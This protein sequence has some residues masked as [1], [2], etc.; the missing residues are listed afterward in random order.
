LAPEDY[1]TPEDYHSYMD[2]TYGGRI[3]EAN[4]PFTFQEQGN[5]SADVDHSKAAGTTRQL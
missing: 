3:L 1:L 2:E 5:G 4:P